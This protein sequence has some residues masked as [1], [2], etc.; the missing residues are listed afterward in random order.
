MTDRFRQQYTPV[1]DQQKGFMIE[2]KKKATELESLLSQV[3]TYSNLESKSD[4][5]KAEY[6]RALSIATTKLEES[7][8]W[9]VK[10]ASTD[11]NQ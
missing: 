4:K 9:A 10:A 6:G 2:I 5:S 3:Q 8:M 1:T 7:V 11:L